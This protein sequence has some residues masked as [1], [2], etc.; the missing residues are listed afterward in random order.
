MRPYRKIGDTALFRLIK[1]ARKTTDET[2]IQRYPKADWP[3]GLLQPLN[4]WHALEPYDYP[5]CGD[6]K[7]GFTELSGLRREQFALQFNA[8]MG[9]AQGEGWLLGFEWWVDT[10]PPGD[11]GQDPPIARFSRILLPQEPNTVG[12]RETIG[13]GYNADEALK[14]AAAGLDPSMFEGN[15]TI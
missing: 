6:A 4:D 2:T 9:T 3:T 14:N 12:L 11:F 5:H 7:W 10:S 13:G 15:W 1:Q 8:L